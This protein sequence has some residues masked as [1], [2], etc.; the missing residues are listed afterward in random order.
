[1]IEHLDVVGSYKLFGKVGADVAGSVDDRPASRVHD[2]SPRSERVKRPMTIR[3]L[4]TVDEGL[5]VTMFIRI[6]SDG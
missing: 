5:N 6:Q 3:A 2:E 4:E 1:V